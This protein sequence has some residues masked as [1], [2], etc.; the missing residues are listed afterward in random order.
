[1]QIE[2]LK[3][4]PPKV[5]VI[6]LS[7]NGRKFLEQFLPSVVLHQKTDYEIYV[8]D[9]AS[10]D[11]SVI[12]LKKYFP[13][14]HIINLQKNY[15]F[16]LGYNEALKQVIA[17]YF[18]LLNQ[19]VEVST[20]WV[21][22]VIELMEKDSQIAV[23]QPKIKSFTNKNYFE[24]AGAA[25]G[26]IDNYGYPFCRGR[27]FDTVEEDHGQYD[28]PTEIFWASGACFFVRTELYRKFGG[29][30]EHF[31]AH[32]EEIDLCWRLKNAGYKIFYTPHSA[33]Y[34]VGGGSLPQ[35]NPKKTFL[36]FRNNLL[37]LAK[38]LPTEVRFRKIL[39]R[40]LL[41]HI[42][43]Y[44]ELFKGNSGNYFAI[45]RSHF[46]FLFR[47]KVDFRKPVFNHPNKNGIYNSSIIWQYFVKNKK[48][49]SQLKRN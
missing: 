23:C 36:N 17:D 20:N 26:W 49:F 29:L 34:H 39:F 40:L 25:G 32:M 31:F 4:T 38:N 35:G 3:M 19:D 9:N 13:S 8:A 44:T 30:D 43:A 46:E 47:T 41:D 10:T 1:M 16:A 7:W 33:V 27:I 42:A 24:Y 15:G 11:D 6:I 21:N 28:E 14:V 5:A 12:F 22:P 48:Y 37:M 45:M 18:V 2:N